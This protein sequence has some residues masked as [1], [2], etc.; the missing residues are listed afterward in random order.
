MSPSNDDIPTGDDSGAVGTDME[1]A[2]AALAPAPWPPTGGGEVVE[3]C[4]EL[5]WAAT[6]LGPVEA[7]PAALR[8]LV[9]AC[10]EA[11]MPMNLWCGDDLVL[12]YN[13]GYRRVLADKH[14]RALGRPVREVWSEIWPDIGPMA[15]R[16]LEQG[17]PSYDEDAPFV[18]ERGG[19]REDAWF[20][21]SLSPIRDE[22]GRVVA[23]LNVAAETTGRILAERA[24]RAAQEAAQRAEARLRDVF[25]SAPAF[26]AAL[27]GPD[28][29]FEFVNDAYVRLIGHRDVVGLP[30]AEA[31]PEVVDQGF[32][33][34]LD[35]VLHTGEPFIGRETPIMLARARG[36]PVEQRFLDF[37]YQP[38]TD[39]ATGERVGVVAHGSDVTDQ[40]LARREIERLLGESEEG[41]RRLEEANEQLEQQQMELELTAQQLQENAT[42]LEA[43]TEALDEANSQLVLSEKRLR[44]VFDQAPLALAVLTGP[45][46]TYTLVSPRYAETPGGGRDLIGRSSREA[47]PELAGQGIHELMDRVY[48]TGEQYVEAE[49]PVELDHDGDGVG[50][51]F[52]FNVSYQ[53][54]RDATGRIYGIVSA[55]QDVTAQVRARHELEESREAAEAARRE[56]EEANRAKADFLATMSHEL[57][58]PL[59]A[60]A[61]YADLLLLGVRGELTPG[62]AEDVSRMRRSGQHLLALINDVLNFAKLEAGQVEFRIEEVRLHDVL[63]G[64]ED[65]IRPQ[66]SAKR[67]EYA[68]GVCD[69]DLRV[70]ADPEKVRQVLLNLLANAVKFTAPGG[71]VAL[72]CET[73]AR[74]VRVKVTDT[75]HGIAADQMERIFDP[76]VQVDRHLTPTSQQG[77]GLGLAISRDLARAMGGTLTAE[78]EPGR[79]STFTLALRR[80]R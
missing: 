51:R 21:F 56:A 35:Q 20:T 14:P 70:C 29:V 74:W 37:V 77:V 58:T 7:W 6:P 12:I 19:R 13:E 8:T 52:Y 40:V 65:L 79:G 54:L 22:R 24:L 48:A 64:L 18:V 11:P 75:G 42:E 30:V 57:R 39:S 72:A 38:L 67:L 63:A 61:G 71:S 3:L 78:S 76:F 28:H 41:R 80:P 9:R 55:S 10:L 27:R 60:I 23:L 50:E 17:E 33:G 44:D 43:Q 2:S 66:I 46:H 59:N 25:V 68:H 49:R 4:R 32:V 62:Q 73:D 5:D 31:L 1:A 53:P 34:L 47:F 36:E 26:M 15:R 45:E 69:A 16:I